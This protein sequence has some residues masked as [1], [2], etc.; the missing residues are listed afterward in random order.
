MTAATASQ[1]APAGDYSIA[2]DGRARCASPCRA[3]LRIVAGAPR[4]ASSNRRLRA[5]PLRSVML[6][7]PRRMREPRA[8]SLPTQSAGKRT[9]YKAIGSR[10]VE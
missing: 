8:G 1:R 2:G 3:W 7:E 10:I 6:G 4:G 5:G 9:R